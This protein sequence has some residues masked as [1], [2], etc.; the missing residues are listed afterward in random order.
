MK[1]DL[2]DDLFNEMIDKMIKKISTPRVFGQEADIARVFQGSK[3][4]THVS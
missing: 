1:A 3:L 2:G 4:F